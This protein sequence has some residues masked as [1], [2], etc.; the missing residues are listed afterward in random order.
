M[1]PRNPDW[2]DQARVR[3]VF[4][5]RC[6]VQQYLATAAFFAALAAA[7]PAVS[8]VLDLVGPLAWSTRL[9]LLLYAWLP[10]GLGA[11]ALVRPY[12]LRLAIW[13]EDHPQS[14]SAIRRGYVLP[15]KPDFDEPYVVWGEVHPAVQL[16]DRGDLEA[17]P[18]VKQEYSPVP[19]WLSSAGPGLCTGNLLL[20]ATGTGKTSYFL[21][22][23]VF[24][25]FHHPAKVGGL[26]MDAKASL[27]RPLEA[28]MKAAGREADLLP[29]GPHR[30]TTWNPL[31][32][33]EAEP[34]V[35]A[36]RL[37]VVNENVRGAKYGPETRWIRD[38][39]TQVATGA[40]AILRLTTGY[41]TAAG[42]TA[43]FAAM[44][45]AIA[46]SDTP[47]D[48]ARTWIESL[49]SGSPP[50]FDRVYQ[51][52]VQLLAT[53][54]GQD[55]K[56]RAIYFA[57]LAALLNPLIAPSVYDKF[58][59]PLSALDMPAW[60]QLINEGRVVVLDA[61]ALDVPGLAVILGTFLKLGFQHAMLARPAWISRSE[62][63]AERYMAL[64]VDEWQQFVSISDSEYL[65]LARE[66]RAIT[67]FA[68]QSFD[69][70]RAVVGEDQARVIL[71]NLRTRLILGQTDPTFAADLIGQTDIEQTD[72]NVTESTQGAALASSGRFTGDTTVAQS[73]S[74]RQTREHLVKPELIKALPVGQ[75]FIELFD[76]FQVQPVQR[77]FGMLP[78][79]PAGTRY[80]DLHKGA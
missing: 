74:L 66:S 2:L 16:N 9:A 70:I 68:T 45:E 77:V 47:A 4:R 17:V 43:F 79:R 65:A 50:L 8:G 6:F 12:T 11:L 35:L 14:Q 30:P 29:V 59:P 44:Q 37:M 76:G 5:A 33:P 56:Y 7:V 28:E 24:R 22:P 38:G 18:Q 3:W 25:L 55:E 62:C 31:H 73:Y 46:G 72:K 15:D 32:A 51:N 78:D 53:A 20:G 10:A 39:A 80:A 58:N 71:A 42:L 57:E 75:A 48:D 54:C 49:F 69:A 13:L 63:N 61:N 21:R 1:Q 19:G 67:V 34:A 60:P 64:I 23:A 40:I 36:E 52:A 27:V 26:V 41:V